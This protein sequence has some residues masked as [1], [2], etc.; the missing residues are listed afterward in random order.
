MSPATDSDNNVQ[1]SK[2]RTQPLSSLTPSFFPKNDMRNVDQQ[3]FSS[4]A[5]SPSTSTT[6]TTTNT[7][8]LTNNPK[9]KYKGR[10]SILDEPKLMALCEYYLETKNIT[11]LALIARQRGLPPH[12]RCKIWPL[13]LRNHPFVLK[14]YITP[15]VE[16]DGDDDDDDD[17]YYIDEN[18]DKNGQ[19]A[20]VDS[21]KEN[22]NLKKKIHHD[23]KKYFKRSNHY[24]DVGNSHNTND[25]DNIGNGNGNGNGN[26]N[27]NGKVPGN[28]NSNEKI[29]RN[30]EFNEI[31]QHIFSILESSILKFFKKWGSLI[32]Y[33]SGLT[34]VA[35]GLA[36]WYP[37]ILGTNYVLCGRDEVSKY[38]RTVLKNINDDFYD[39]QQPFPTDE[40][41]SQRSVDIGIGSTALSSPSRSYSYNIS[42]DNSSVSSSN[43]NNNSLHHR[44]LKNMSFSEVYERLVLVILH[45]PE[46]KP[47]LQEE[48]MKGEQ[49]TLHDSAG[50]YVEEDGIENEEDFSETS[51]TNMLNV[52]RATLPIKGGTADERI[53]FMLYCL[54]RLLPELSQFFTEEDILNSPSTKNDDWIIF[55]L[56]WCGAKV[57]SRL[58]RGRIWDMLLGW[59]LY[60]DIK[61]SNLQEEIDDLS[62]DDEILTLLGPDIY[63]HPLYSEEQLKK[64][65]M[66]NKSSNRRESLKSLLS[67]LSLNKSSYLSNSSPDDKPITDYNSEVPY[68]TLDAHTQ[69]V[70]ISLSFLKQKEFAI[71][72]LEQN[73]IREFL[74]K[75]SSSKLDG[76]QKLFEDEIKSGAN[77]SGNENVTTNESELPPPAIPFTMTPPGNKHKKST[78]A[79]RDIENIIIES[80]ELWRKWVWQEIVEENV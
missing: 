21:D 27:E 16:V 76:F 31:E 15:D 53:S 67:S 35:L 47:E 51:S 45:S 18:N 80:G 54:R 25:N 71:L 10:A 32:N 55:W 66:D 7:M 48:E 30:E 77:S 42:N 68:S 13:L 61:T 20:G 62:I 5:S 34:W 1:P 37:P 70:F 11:G 60:E 23:L 36:E 26:N 72:E 4:Q 64:E 73:E 59:R 58:D 6:T 3:F 69:I 41:Q 9:M 44:H 57:W 8:N 65:N 33:H 50:D 24:I 17:N 40:T 46:P 49:E 52:L 56:K 14:P 29:K 12:L 19:S 38:G 75:T 43:T 22:E 39:Y 79:L 63:W 78:M 28:G 74:N 2:I